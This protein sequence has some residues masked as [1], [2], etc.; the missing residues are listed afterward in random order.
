MGLHVAHYHIHSLPFTLVGGFQ[1]GISFPNS[2]GIAQED[3]QVA[4]LLR[5]VFGLDLGKQFIGIGTG[6]VGGHALTILR[7]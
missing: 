5:L 2:G 3:L 7:F 1:H 4:A 6:G